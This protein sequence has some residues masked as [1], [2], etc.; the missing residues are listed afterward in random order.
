MSIDPAPGP[1]RP[2]FVERQTYRRRRLVDAA[3]A[4]PLLGLL[5]WCVPL[6]WLIPE[7]P[8]P[9]ST[10]LVYLFV[11]WAGLVVGAAAMIFALRRA[12]PIETGGTERPR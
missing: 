1:R 12:R 3:R 10:A 4:L 5:L 9:T 2:L 8:L 6:L 7:E 11:V